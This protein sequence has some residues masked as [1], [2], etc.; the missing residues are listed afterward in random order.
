LYDHTL[1]VTDNNY[2]A[3]HNRGAAYNGLGNYKQA[4][5]DYSVGIEIK[6]YL[7]DAYI[8][9]G[10]AYDGLGNY[11]QAIED[12]SRAIEIT[13]GSVEAYTNRG[14][15]YLTQGNKELGC[16]DAQKACE[17]ENCKLLEMAKGKG[18]CR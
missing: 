12:Y 7:A 4:I 1:K 6:P 15:A 3:Y 11:K 17:L 14:T 16:H 9:R 13:S 5:E 8:G 2:L 10:F 18:D